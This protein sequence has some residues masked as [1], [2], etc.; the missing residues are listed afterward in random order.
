[1]SQA[2]QMAELTRIITCSQKLEQLKAL[3]AKGEKRTLE[4]RKE[5][6]KTVLALADAQMESFAVMNPVQPELPS[7]ETP[8][9][10]Q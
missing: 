2:T 4:R 5:E 8:A 3:L 10:N 6:W 7:N 1:M 9:P